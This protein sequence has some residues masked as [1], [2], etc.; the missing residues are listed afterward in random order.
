[1]A[2][3]NLFPRYVASAAKTPMYKK[4]QVDVSLCGSKLLCKEGMQEREAKCCVRRG[5]SDRVLL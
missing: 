4:V 3:R 2:F 1:M 5:R